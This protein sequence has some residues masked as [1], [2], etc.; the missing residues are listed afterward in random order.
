MRVNAQEAFVEGYEAHNVQ[1]RIW[2][3][4]MQLHAVNKENPTKKFVGRDRETA[5]EESEEHYLP[6]FVGSG[7]SI[8]AGKLHLR[9][10]GEQPEL[11][12]LA[13]VALGELGSLPSCDPGFSGGCV[14]SGVRRGLF[15]THDGGGSDWWL[16]EERKEW[17]G[18]WKGRAMAR[19]GR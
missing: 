15:L 9:H 8:V 6:A 2:R 12:H 19:G 4:L 18:L 16:E 11:A 10:R 1:D 3:E 13:E 17:L 7:H 5:K 14:A